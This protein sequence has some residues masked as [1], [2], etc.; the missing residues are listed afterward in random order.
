MRRYLKEY[1]AAPQ[2]S[3]ISFP[4]FFSLEI[5]STYENAIDIRTDIE[6]RKIIYE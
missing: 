3:I 4:T 5:Q 1:G 2:L 6:N